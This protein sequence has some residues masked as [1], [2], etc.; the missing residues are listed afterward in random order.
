MSM[1]LYI[2]TPALKPF[3]NPC[4]EAMVPVQYM[5]IILI[6]WWLVADSLQFEMLIVDLVYSL[7]C[8]WLPW[9]AAWDA[10]C[11]DGLQPRMQMVGLV[12]G[13]RCWWMAWWAAWDTDGWDGLQSEMLMVGRRCAAWDVDSWHGLLS[14]VEM[15]GRSA[16]WDVGWLSLQPWMV[17]VFTVRGL[18]C[19]L[20][21][22]SSL[23]F[24]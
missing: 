1:D 5:E 3:F 22:Q 21:T 16:D 4:K 8:W 9:S 17:L 13:L 20:L 14:V 7:R 19:R 15:F 2:R 18:R 10:D 6:C 12:C 23:I 24:W 11:W